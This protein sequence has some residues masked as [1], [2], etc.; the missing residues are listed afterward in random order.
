[1][2]C[3]VILPSF[4]DGLKTAIVHAKFKNML[5]D[6]FFSGKIPN[7]PEAFPLFS[8][9]SPFLPSPLSLR[10]LRSFTRETRKSKKEK[11]CY[12]LFLTLRGIY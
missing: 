2:W 11:S 7:Y 3:I 6:E 5:T 1:M 4:V 10:A 12:E 8:E 9:K